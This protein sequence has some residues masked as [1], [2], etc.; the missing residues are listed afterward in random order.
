MGG[1]CGGEL[2]Q[3]GRNKLGG[4]LHTELGARFGSRV[5]SELNMA[6]AEKGAS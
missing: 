6:C 5:N 2:G 3:A 4:L 1:R